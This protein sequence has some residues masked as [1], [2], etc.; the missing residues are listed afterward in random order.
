MRLDIRDREA[1]TAVSPAALSAYAHTEGWIKGEPYG[2]YSDV[3]VKEGQREIIVP[4][5]QR[6]GDYASVMSQLIVIFAQDA[7]VDELSIYRDLV[8]SDRDVIRVRADAVGNGDVALDVGVD[9]MVGARSMLLAAACSLWDQRPIYRSDEYEYKAAND[10][11]SRMRLGQTEQGSYIITL[12]TPSFDQESELANRDPIY[13]QIT[14]RLAGALTATREAIEGTKGKDTELFFG[15]LGNGV[16]A[17]LCNALVRMINPV[18]ALDV[19]LTW[20]RTLP[21]A[22]TREVIR[23][24]ND[25]VP[26]LRNAARSFRDHEFLRG[27][28]LTGVVQRLESDEIERGGTMTMSAPIGERHRRVTAVLNQF[29]Y[30]R[31]L[32]AHS[33]RLRIIAE[34][35]LRRAGQQW[36]LLDPSIVEVLSAAGMTINE[37][38]V[39]AAALN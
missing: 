11:L 36:T 27:T 38:D 39:E 1:L 8:T 22:D 15:A 37:A 13:R 4:R 19:N 9:L 33:A 7:E 20:A 23:F 17:N 5:T 3:Y 30:R 32:Q 18:P 24:A 16:N 2:D 29:D 31:A 10:Y 12:L 28:R 34:G 14:R 6:I 25:D 26:V 21:V 35:T